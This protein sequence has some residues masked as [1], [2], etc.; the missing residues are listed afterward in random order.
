MTVI[1]FKLGWWLK[2]GENILAAFW[3]EYGFSLLELMVS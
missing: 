1:K 2:Y 3:L